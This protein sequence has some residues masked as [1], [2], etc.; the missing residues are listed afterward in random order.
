MPTSFIICLICLLTWTPCCL[1]QEVAE[2]GNDL[3]YVEAGGYGGLG[4][5]NYERIS[6]RKQLFQ[7]G[8]RIGVGFNRFMDYRNKFNPDVSIPFGVNFCYGTKWKAEIGL[9][10]TFSSVVH[11]GPDLEPERISQVHGNASIGFRYQK[12]EGGLLIRAGYSPIFEKFSYLRH[13]PYL[14]IGIVF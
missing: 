4:S 1:A 12:T 9:G 2:S 8:P 3:I 10:T 6:Y 5:I 7:L 11:V 14:A 13:W